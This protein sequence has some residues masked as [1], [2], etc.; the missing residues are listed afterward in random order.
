SD[1]FGRDPSLSESILKQIATW[2]CETHI[3]HVLDPHECEPRLEGEI[4]LQDVETGE[5]RR[6]W[7]TKREMER[8]AESMKVF[9]ETI[10]SG[11][12]KRKIDYLCWQTNQTFENLFLALL[13]RGSALAGK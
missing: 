13:M 2:P 5:V 12:T 8:Y 6:M 11:C 7:L 3:I 1:L 9:R 4:E 10:K